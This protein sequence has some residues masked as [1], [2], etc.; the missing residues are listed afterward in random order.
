MKRLPSLLAAIAT[1]FP[2]AAL[3][4]TTDADSQR[5]DEIVVTAER[6]S[7][8]LQDV[9]MSISATT[10]E[11]LAESSIFDTEA[12][13]STVPGLVLQRDVVGKAVIRGIGTEN[14]TVG[15]DPGVA[16]YVDGAYMARSS[17]AIFDFFDVERVEVLRG[18][19]GTLYG[20]NATGGVINVISRAPTETFEGNVSLNVGDFGMARAEGAISGQLAEGVR[21]RIA[22][23]YSQRDG[24]TDNIFPGAGGRDLDEL[25]S[26]DL[27]A[28]RGRLDIDLGERAMLELIADIYRDDSN[29][30]AFWYTDDTLPWQSPGSQFPR[31]FRTVSQG[32]EAEVP[33]FTS[34]A[35]GSANRQDQTGLTARLTWEGERVSVTSVSSF[36]DIEFDWINDGDGI[37]DFLV[38]Y[39]QR[40][41]SEQF[42]QDIQIA[43]NTDS[44]FQ[45]ITGL[46]YL[47][48]DSEGL[49][50]I[51]LGPAFVPPGG[52]TV[53]FDGTNETEAFGVFA[54]GSYDFGD[55]TVT[56]GVRYSDESK[57]ATLATPLFEG[58]T[59]FP[60][61][62]QD[63]S[64]D[65]ITP[66]FVIEYRAADN[67]N[68]HGS[69][70]RGFKSGGYS[71]LDNPINAFDEETIWAYEVGA[72]TQFAQNRMRFNVSAFVYDYE[73]QQ[74]SQVTNL[75]T[76]TSNA[77]SSSIWG[78]EA[79]FSAL[80]GDYLR[81]DGNIAFL[82]T[83][84]DE[85]CTTDT[86]NTALALDPGNCTFDDGAGGTFVTPNL[87]GNELPRAPDLTA[88]LAATYERSLTNTLDGFVRAEWQHTGDQFFSVFNR[89]NV[90]QD[91]YDLFNASIGVSASDG[92]WNARLWVRNLA[93]EEYFSNL[94]ESGV[95]DALVIPQ[96]F[97]GP[98][99]T[100]GVSV[101]FNF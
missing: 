64:F 53:V 49:Y 76:Q 23:L 15:G 35:V 48:E 79:E 5:I 91:A 85:F 60:V 59:T 94:F 101:G 87:A 22:G 47:T 38:V 57:D 46:F 56:A 66:R 92:R 68:L 54:E 70:T 20:R 81:L 34:L 93:D 32:Y 84:F 2:A 100:W 19:Q 42:S 61:Q 9:P 44:P 74:L 71:L 21:G 26:K 62:R 98:P 58:D 50:A 75:A 27:W 8:T 82:D 10:G 67:I 40:D 39:F 45:W 11:A 90:A 97:A 18:P 65:A 95:T 72:K 69:A 86:R 51:P 28:V 24:F 31:D 14:F 88:F 6:R 13:A 30:P 80:V 99:R 83:E 89:P 17:T 29:P 4:Q 7:E 16:V 41:E 37:S 3:A 78:L 25:D 12:L 52:F 36:R 43:S 1:A 33:G 96:G 55:F 77:G 73:D 63:D